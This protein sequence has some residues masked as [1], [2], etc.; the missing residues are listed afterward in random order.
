MAI[1]D[2]SNA[3]TTSWRF[4]GIAFVASVFF[5]LVAEPASA[6]TVYVILCSIVGIIQG[7][8]G[9]AMATLA[10]LM[11][12]IGA[13]YGKVSWPMAIMVAVGVSVIFGAQTLVSLMN[14]TVAGPGC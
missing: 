12:G 8:M 3:L 6:S 5:A 2:M 14:I 4:V 9:R 7:Q 1:R 11:L 13:L 10:V